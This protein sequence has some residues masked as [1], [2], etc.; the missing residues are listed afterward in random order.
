MASESPANLGTDSCADSTRVASDSL[1]LSG[2]G[3]KKPAAKKPRVESDVDWSEQNR[4]WDLRINLDLES[5]N[6]A[7]AEHELAAFCERIKAWSAVKY[8]FVGG[9]E[10]GSNPATDDY[11][12]LHSHIALI[13]KSPTTRRSVIHN[14]SLARFLYGD[15]T[16]QPRS[17]YLA[18]RNPFASFKGWREHHSKE[19]TKV[20]A[21]YIALEYGDPPKQYGNEL[22]E[23]GKPEKMKQDDMLREVGFTYIV[24]VLVSSVLIVCIHCADYAIV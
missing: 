16:G 5:C 22:I 17:Y 23:R 14:L 7:V 4:Q 2:D 11:Q 9:V 1:V 6:L 8:S 20:G 21:S 18:A 19:A 24:V 13:L 12:K 10:L 15:N 3:S